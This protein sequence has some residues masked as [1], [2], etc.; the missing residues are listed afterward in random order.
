ME[1]LFIKRNNLLY[2]DNFLTFPYTIDFHIINLKVEKIL[3]SNR[4][5]LFETKYLEIRSVFIHE[6]DVLLTKFSIENLK[7]F[8][9]AWCIQNYRKQF[10]FTNQNVIPRVLSIN[11]DNFNRK[12]VSINCPHNVCLHRK[13]KTKVKIRFKIFTRLLI[14]IFDPNRKIKCKLNLNFNNIVKLLFYV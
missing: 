4:K 2:N 8:N 14:K 9:R 6:T 5:V 3:V 10:Y 12:I 11:C 1:N 7:R 13:I